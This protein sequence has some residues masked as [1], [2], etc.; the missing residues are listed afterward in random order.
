M[1]IL[2]FFA[3]IMLMP[4]VLVLITLKWL[5]GLA[6]RFT[7]SIVGLSLILIAASVVYCVISQRWQ[8]LFV[9][10][11]TGGG[12]IGC[13][14]LLVLFQEGINSLINNISETLT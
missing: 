12:I 10:V 5:I 9:F 4:I 14:F 11:L 3:K 6:M 7:A 2:R 8:E 1:A 13:M